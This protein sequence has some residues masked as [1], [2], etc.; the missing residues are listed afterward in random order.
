MVLL[1]DT[2]LTLTFF[3]FSRSNFFEPQFG[4][5][6]QARKP[7]NFK[8]PQTLYLILRLFLDDLCNRSY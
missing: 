4:Q 6:G 1:Q 5:I 8:I 7:F 3:P 2:H